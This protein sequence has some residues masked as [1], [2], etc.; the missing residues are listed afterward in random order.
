MRFKL[1]VKQRH[2]GGISTQF[3]EVGGE[4]CLIGRK[5]ADVHLNEPRCSRSHVLIYTRENELRLRDLQSRNGTVLNGR[6]IEDATLRVGDEIRIGGAT[7][8][9]VDVRADTEPV[10][11]PKQPGRANEVSI[12]WTKEDTDTLEEAAGQWP[13]V[14]GSLVLDRAEAFAGYIPGKGSRF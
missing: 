6:R 12:A 3:L 7:L 2:P 10:S 9:L 13:A 1:L 8:I 11:E 14:D 5:D 4:H